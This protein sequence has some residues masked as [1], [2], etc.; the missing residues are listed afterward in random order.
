MKSVVILYFSPL[1]SFDTFARMG[2]QT[3]RMS[4]LEVLVL[5]SLYDLLLYFQPLILSV[6]SQG[7]VPKKKCIEG[8]ERDW[9][10]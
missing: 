10:K 2:S 9:C 3:L 8:Y 5:M 6:F 1:I 4:G 7:L